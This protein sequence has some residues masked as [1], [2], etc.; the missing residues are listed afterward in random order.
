MD[1]VA[2]ISG[3]KD[4]CYNIMHCMNHGHRIVALA[5][6]QPH[7]EGEMDSYMYQSV[8]SE[9]IEAIA[10]AIDIPLYQL[11]TQG[12][13]KFRDLFYEETKND[14][15]EDLYKLLQIVKNKH[16]S[17][18]GVSSGAICSNYQRLRVENVCS[19]L[20]LISLSYLWRLEQSLLLRE[21]VE[22]G[23]DAIIVKIGSLGLTIEGH[24]G[25]HLSELEPELLRL[26]RD[27]GLNV[28]GEGGE[29][30]TLTL[31][32]PFFKQKVVV[33]K[34]EIIEASKDPYS[35][36]AYL[37]ILE[38]HLENKITEEF[39]KIPIPNILKNPLIELF[40]KSDL[41]MNGSTNCVTDFAAKNSSHEFIK[42]CLGET[43]FCL[44]AFA[45]S[46]TTDIT[47]GVKTMFHQIQ[48]ELVNHK[49]NFT[50]IINSNL[51]LTNMNNFTPIN[52]IYFQYFKQQPPSRVC[53]QTIQ[54][55]NVILKLELI[56]V[57]EDNRLCMHVQSHSYWAPANIGPYA[58]CY[59]ANAW[60]FVAGQIGL[61]P[62]D[63]K[64][65]AVHVQ[66]QLSI[67]HC[68]AI[69]A[70]NASD[71][72][73][74]ITGTCYGT[75]KDTLEQ[76]HYM[77][78]TLYGTDVTQHMAYV[79]IPELPKSAMCEW[80]LT[81]A[82]SDKF[83]IFEKLTFE[84]ATETYK[85]NVTIFSC[86]RDAA[87]T[88]HFCSKE[89]ISEI[90]FGMLEKEISFVLQ[91]IK[92]KISSY[93]NSLAVIR[94]WTV[95]THSNIAMMLSSCLHKV[96]LEQMSTQEAN[97]SVYQTEGIVYKLRCLLVIQ[98]LIL[99]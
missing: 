97:I 85:W 95:L 66:P 47:K 93:S 48:T 55:T 91:E 43:F 78:N 11:V 96:W 57:R 61:N 86:P 94:V 35:P 18:R 40:T 63:M 34:F 59:T 65:S 89:E 62:C 81:A 17:I 67:Q 92:S 90:Q 71:I 13:S 98:V 53:I 70:A 42:I 58:Q 25:K 29:Y 31:N 41:F 27:C 46:E 50:Q 12:I 9:A 6:I 23:V 73:C 49:L 69:L 74:Y 21:M 26:E 19:R 2:L 1:V 33:D 87:L 45:F 3:G 84:I 80:H 51:L 77:F 83:S 44:T 8:G 39:S 72:S 20:G 52:T 22:T 88:M 36:A 28:C 32:A 60:V 75:N 30:E 82:T 99:P 37:K 10:K 16:P 64:L 79:I 4:S 14:E 54:D 38:L 68:Q 24:L 76:C 5:N 15:I 7:L 56:G